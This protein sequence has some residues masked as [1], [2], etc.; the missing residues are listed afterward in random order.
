MRENKTCRYKKWDNLP[1][2][3]LDKV[4]QAELEKEQPDKEVVLP[5]LRVLEERE[6]GI[7]IE[8]TPESIALLERISEHKTPF[9]QPTRK[10]QWAA[11]IAAVAATVCI[12]VM[13]IPRTVGAESIFDVLFRWTASVFEFFT[14]EQ[15]ATNPQVEFVFETDN[16][17]LQKL[18]DKVAELGVTEHIVPMWLP[19]GFALSNIRVSTVSAGTKVYAEFKNDRSIILFA[20]RISTDISTAFEKKDSLV[21]VYD[22]ADVSHFVFQNDE[23]LSVAWN[24]EGVECLI[25]TSLSKENIYIMIKSIYRRVVE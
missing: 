8:K 5:I 17:G 2:E 6:D 7:P 16:A 12:V 18:Y 3:E 10:K 20:Y 19:E 24:I 21:E 15:D 9:K 11:G 23:Y 1:T 13:T 4:L 14:P 25:N 22:Y